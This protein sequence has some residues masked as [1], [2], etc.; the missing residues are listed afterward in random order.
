VIAS[1]RR[2]RGDLACV[3][4]LPQKIAASFAAGELLAITLPGFN[5]A[6]NSA[7]GT[8]SERRPAIHFLI[9]EEL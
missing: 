5:M 6:E 4:V 1:D 8:T 7:F 2:E 3:T 9:T